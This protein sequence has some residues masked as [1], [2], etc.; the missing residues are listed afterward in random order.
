MDTEL[1]REFD[2]GS[3]DYKYDTMNE[4]ECFVMKEVA[5]RLM[6]DVGDVLYQ[7]VYLWENLVAAVN[8][9]NAE[10]SQQDWI[11]PQTS[12]GNSNNHNVVIPC[13]VKFIGN[14]T[15]NKFEKDQIENTV[16]MEYKHF[17][18]LVNTYLPPSA[19]ASNTMFREW[20]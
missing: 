7:K 16:M 14:W 10:H 9:F 11:E 2:I 13:R 20:F 19:L 5:D 4:G 8:I 1:E 18:K 15:Y 3:R 6:L 17:F 12:F